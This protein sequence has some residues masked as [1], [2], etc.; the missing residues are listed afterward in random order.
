MIRGSK[1]ILRPFSEGFSEAELQTQFRWS[2]DR[3]IVRWS[4]MAPSTLTFAEFVEQFRS[5]NHYNSSDRALFAVLTA[6]QGALIGRIGCFNINMESRQ[7]ELGVV[8]GEKDYWSKG[9]GRDAVCT[10]L[11]HI[12]RHTRLQK[13]YLYTLEENARARRSF[14]SCGFKE[15]AI[16]KRFSFE[17]GEYED[18][19]MEITRQEWLARKRTGNVPAR[20]VDPQ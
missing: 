2:K 11:D 6:D 13:I 16:N 14:T 9:Y 1:I 17:G 4:N 15:I 12:F 19:K 18:V 7:A 10:L 8:I 20:L 3:D 5:H